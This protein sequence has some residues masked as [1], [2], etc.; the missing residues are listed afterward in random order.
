MLKLL[1]DQQFH[2]D[3]FYLLATIDSSIIDNKL[4]DQALKHLEHK[5]VFLKI[6]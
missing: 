1:L 2:P 6:N 5:I 3:I 4:L